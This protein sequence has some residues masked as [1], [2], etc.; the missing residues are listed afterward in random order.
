MAKAN[1]TRLSSLFMFCQARVA[2]AEHVYL[3]DLTR[4]LVFRNF[5]IGK[6]FLGKRTLF[7]S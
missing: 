7:R 4:V 6:I 5:V 3:F 1:K 2:G